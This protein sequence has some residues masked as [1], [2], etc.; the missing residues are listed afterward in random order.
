MS[1][2]LE[3]WDIEYLDGQEGRSVRSWNGVA[4]SWEHAFDMACGAD[5]YMG[6]ILDTSQREPT[7]DEIKEY[8]GES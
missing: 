7:E 6:K 4:K 1:E 5:Y 3:W 8:K 2:E